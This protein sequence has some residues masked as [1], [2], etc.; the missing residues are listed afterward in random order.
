MLRQAV[1]SDGSERLE[2]ATVLPINE[3]DFAA[4][5]LRKEITREVH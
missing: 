2:R 4:E 5:I 3:T 1:F